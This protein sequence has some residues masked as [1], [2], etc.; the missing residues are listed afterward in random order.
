MKY[1]QENLSDC[2]LCPEY[3]YTVLDEKSKSQ[4]FVTSN[5]CGEKKIVSYIPLK[6]VNFET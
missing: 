6:L 4:L 1:E 3:S 5:V 2:L